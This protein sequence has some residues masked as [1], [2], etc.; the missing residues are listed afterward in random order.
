MVSEENMTLDDI[1]SFFGTSY[2]FHLA[3]GWSHS[4]Y[5]TWMKKGYIPIKS[6]IKLEEF[7]MGKLKASLVD[8]RSNN[9]TR[10][11]G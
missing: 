2:N 6:Q 8:L 5:N 10:T 1:K 11:T 4:C 9:D 7:T 3:T